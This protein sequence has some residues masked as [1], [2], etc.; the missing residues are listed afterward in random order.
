MAIS[1]LGDTLMIC[2]QKANIT[3]LKRWV[4]WITLSTISAVMRKLVF[5]SKYEISKIF[6]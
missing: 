6:K 4:V 2:E 3:L 5:S 1:N